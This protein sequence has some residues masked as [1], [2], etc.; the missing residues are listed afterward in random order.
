[1]ARRF[2]VLL[3][4]LVLGVLFLAVLAGAGSLALRVLLPPERLREMVVAQLEKRLDREVRLTAVS[5][6]LV[7]G[8]VVEGLEVSEEEGFGEGVFAAAGRARL[9]I[10]WL[11]LARRKVVADTVYLEDARFN[12]VRRLDRTLNIPGLGGPKKR[13][14]MRKNGAAPLELDVRHV[15]VSRGEF[16]YRNLLKKTGWELSSISVGA[17]NVAADGAFP[18]EVSLRAK[19]FFTESVLE[20]DVT[21][22]GMLDLAGFDPD[23]MSADVASF[24]TKIWG[25]DAAA[26]GTIR[27]FR[28]PEF[29]IDA[30]LMEA[31]AVAAR[32]KLDI[33]LVPGTRI[34]A[35]RR[36]K[37][38]DM[39][40][41]ASVPSAGVSLLAR[42]LKLPDGLPML[43][44]TKVSGVF[45][46]QGKDLEVLSFHASSPIGAV[47]ASGRVL[48]LGPKS[49]PF[50]EVSGEI[51]IP[52]F[53]AEDLG[54]LRR[55]PRGLS[56][57]AS[58]VRGRLRLAPKEVEFRSL[59]VELGP[60]TVE[61]EGRLTRDASGR[62]RLGLRTGKVSLDAGQ[63]GGL[64]P[65]TR[66]LGLSGTVDGAL[67]LQGAF[68]SLTASGDFSLK[69]L[70]GEFKGIQV[71]G[72][73][74]EGRLKGR[75]VVFDRLR[76]RAAGG[77]LTLS[78]ALTGLGRRLKVV[79]EGELDRLDLE[80]LL[81]PAPESVKAVPDA[82]PAAV[83][84]RAPAPLALAGSFKVGEVAHPLFSAKDLELA[85]DLRDVTKDLSEIDGVSTMTAVSGRFRSLDAL[86]SK[87]TV[88]KVLLMP[89]LAV[90]QV[91]RLPG[92]NMLPD[93][94]DVAFTRIHGVYVFRS[95]VMEVRQCRLSSLT[96]D[97]DV[98]GTVDFKT[99]RL[100]LDATVR[101]LKLPLPIKFGITGPLREPKVRLNTVESLLSP[102]LGPARKLFEL[103]S[104]K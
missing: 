16:S 84:R 37:A 9:R 99:D 67:S 40:L 1:M 53:E 24:H 54:F 96:L 43:P 25:I 75:D 39:R 104:P 87:S 70:A 30:A 85:W 3:K 77:E 76:G 95:G 14:R 6:G 64:I 63:A 61:F 46:L 88:A 10:R 19:R 21:A 12:L 18:V 82:R 103:F 102:V 44:E 8:L 15:E 27:R 58:R 100:G 26:S 42:K 50:L 52:A 92:L 32:G 97:L 28:S 66:K 94:T 11:P 33:D 41:A 36:K 29:R 86:C 78:L 69:G 90:Q 93:L 57:P 91:Q 74:G 17:S 81:A 55:V 98:G 31:G 72:L 7:Q 48:A 45:K 5:V 49:Q 101:V 73:S 13:R 62:A 60:S 47:D 38:L 59:A 4:T 79:L 23:R 71:S 65:R 51:D 35:G 68:G 83:T 34:E 80:K 89:L 2:G 20:G 56:V 22:S